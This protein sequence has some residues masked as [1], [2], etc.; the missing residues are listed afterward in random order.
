MFSIRRLLVLPPNV[1]A[2]DAARLGSR[3]IGAVLIDFLYG[4]IDADLAR[5]TYLT[6]LCGLFA[7]TLTTMAGEA[8]AIGG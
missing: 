6:D 3:S 5:L 1:E 8:I 2:T 4:P 7:S